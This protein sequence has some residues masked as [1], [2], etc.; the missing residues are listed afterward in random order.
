[1]TLSQNQKVSTLLKKYG[2][3]GLKIAN[4]TINDKNMDKPIHEVVTYFI[5]ETWPNTHHPALIALCCMAAGGKPAQTSKIGAALVLL[6]GAADLH[7]DM[8]DES[9]IKGGK[10]TAYGKFD[11]NLEFKT[12]GSSGNVST[13]GLPVSQV[14]R[15]GMA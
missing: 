4:K 5:E 8:I 13:V 11:K 7:D 14:E 1:M 15:K 2:Q 10:Q 6:T 3:E 9:I 12:G